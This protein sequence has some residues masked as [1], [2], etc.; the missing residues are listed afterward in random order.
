MQEE[1][2]AFHENNTLEL[3]ELPKGKKAIARVGLHRK[4]SRKYTKYKARLVAK[5]Y[6]QIQGIDFQEGFAPVVKMTILWTLFSLS[7]LLDLELYQMYV[8]SAFLHRSLDV[9]L[10]I[11]QLEG[12]TFPN[13]EHLVCKLRAASRG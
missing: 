5:G 4:D 1:I 9:Q 7:A 12:F 2:K 6:K 11:L 10:Y 3:V 13:K 8:N